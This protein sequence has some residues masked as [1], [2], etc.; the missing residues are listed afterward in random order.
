MT[1]F[2]NISDSKCT[3]SDRRQ[4]KTFILSTNVETEFS[5]AIFASQSKTLFLAIL[6]PRSSI[7]KSFSIATY[8]VCEHLTQ[9]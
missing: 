5:I 2:L 9:Y 7:V 8:P 1:F 4:P 3:T 6:D